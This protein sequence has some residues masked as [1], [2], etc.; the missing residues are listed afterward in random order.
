MP[1]SG[2]VFL[3]NYEGRVTSANMQTFV[4]EGNKT[5]LIFA[6][7]NSHSVM[8]DGRKCIDCHG[9][10][11]VKKVQ[12]GNFT[13]T[14]LENGD[15]KQA[16]GVIPVVD[17]VSYNFVYHNYKNGKWVPIENPPKPLLQYVGYGKPLS[18]DQLR[19]LARPMGK[20]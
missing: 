11:N 4:T 1:L 17:G 8:K 2:W 5:F 19:K 6:P 3:M 20:K 15:L 18:E 16:K 13:M 12:N 10:E 7:Q 14:W 9:I